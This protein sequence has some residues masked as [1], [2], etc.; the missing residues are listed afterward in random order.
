MRVTEERATQVTRARTLQEFQAAVNASFV[1]LSI[2]PHREHPFAGTIS[3]ASADDLVF[4]E[5]DAAAQLVERTPATI[6]QGGSGYYKMTLLLAG[7]SVLIQDGREVMMRPGDL[8]FYDTSRPYSLLFDESFRTLIMM[9][10]KHRLDFP[11]HVVDGLTAVGLRGEHALASVVG[12]FIAQASP[13]FAELTAQTRTKLALTSLDLINTMFSAIFD[14]QTDARGTRQALMQQIAAYISTN[15]GS[16]ELTPQRIADEHYISIRHLHALF[17]E[18]GMSV[19]T[20]VKKRRLERCRTDLID[21]GCAHLG[22]AA[23][24]MRWGFVDAAHFSRV[25]RAEYGM[26]PREFRLGGAK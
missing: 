24:A 7:T 5:V 23:I 2:T 13:Q 26:T 9:V 18:T 3:A 4:T 14:V 1:P 6:A 22:I 21:P 19:S 20:W 16:H 15:L 8:S 12:Q 10:P 11:E 25:F 17:E